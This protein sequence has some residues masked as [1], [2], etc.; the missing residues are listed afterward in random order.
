M[1][2]TLA[3]V[4]CAIIVID[5][6]VAFYML[7]QLREL[8]KSMN[9]RLDELLLSTKKLARAEGFKAGQETYLS[10]VRRAG[11]ALDGA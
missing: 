9:S 5:V 2:T 8:H 7:C 6:A 4:V 1:S 10:D 3:I 11:G